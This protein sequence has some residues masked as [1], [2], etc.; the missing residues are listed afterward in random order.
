MPIYEYNCE[1][2]GKD[3]EKLV[4]KGDD[5]KICCPCC[6]TDKVKKLISAGCFMGG[7]GI[8]TACSTSAPKGFS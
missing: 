4:F 6:G 2:C 7:S 8:G 1:A 5:E 3:F